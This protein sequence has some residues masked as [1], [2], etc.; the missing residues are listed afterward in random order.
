MRCLRCSI[1]KIA[2]FIVAAY[3]CLLALLGIFQEKLDEGDQSYL[4]EHHRRGRHGQI[5]SHL[6]DAQSIV[7]IS[8]IGIS[9]EALKRLNDQ[10]LQRFLEKFPE[11]R[12]NFSQGNNC[13]Y[14][15]LS[16]ASYF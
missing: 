5:N 13:F 15:F 10:M 8:N 2:L 12:V 4:G 14:C 7:E 11:L 9:Q 16:F 1:L 6:F 3:A